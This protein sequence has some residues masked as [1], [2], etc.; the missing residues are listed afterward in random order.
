MT[1]L[2]IALAAG[3]A[4]FA[5]PL[6]AQTPA[7]A[8]APA[9]VQVSVPFNPPLDR[10][11][12]YRA[13]ATRDQNGAPGT[14]WVDYEITFSRR[15][16]GFRMQV[17]TVDAGAPGLRPAEAAMLRRMMVEMASAFVVLL[18]ADGN[19]EDLEDGEAYWNSLIA[20][21]EQVF[22]ESGDRRSPAAIAQAT[23]MMRQTSPQ[24]RLN[25]VTQ[26]IAPILEFTG[27]AFA[28]GETRTGEGQTEGPMGISVLQQISVTAQ[29]AENGRLHLTMRSTVPQEE[30]RRTLTDFIA[31][32]PSTVRPPGTPSAMAQVAA[33]LRTAQFDRRGEATYEVALDSGLLHR[34][35]AMER[36]EMTIGGERRTVGRGLR[37]ERH[38]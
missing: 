19:M 10:S 8:A 1:R 21:T 6:A 26:Y 7:S 31:N 17:R 32:I 13:T 16:G 27:T 38:D 28:I 35:D 4:A 30:L 34:M 2:F 14:T 3:I 25:T 24:G 29:R 36:T 23:A 22:R 5:T 11:I 33:E 20:A 15:A 37:L 18:N 12:H 9:A